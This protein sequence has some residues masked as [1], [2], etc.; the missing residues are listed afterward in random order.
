MYAFHSGR[1]FA[2]ISSSADLQQKCRELCQDLAE[3]MQKDSIKVHVRCQFSHFSHHEY[4]TVN[5]HF[6]RLLS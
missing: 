3:D 5:M 4:V 2:E 1:T 6:P